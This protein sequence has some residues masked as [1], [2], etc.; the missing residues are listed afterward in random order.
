MDVCEQLPET[1]GRHRVLP[2]LDHLGP[3]IQLL[4]VVVHRHDLEGG[5]HE[6]TRVVAAKPLAQGHAAQVA[7]G[8]VEAAQVSAVQLTGAQ[9]TPD[10]FDAEAFNPRV[11]H[12]GA[13]DGAEQELLGGRISGLR[14][15]R[16]QLGQGI[17]RPELVLGQLDVAPPIEVRRIDE[18][19]VGRQLAARDLGG[20]CRE[21][22]Q[23]DRRAGVK[24]LIGPSGRGRAILEVGGID[25]ETTRKAVDQGIEG[26]AQSLR[27]VGREGLE[28]FDIGEHGGRVPQGA[29]VAAVEGLA[30]GI[31]VLLQGRDR[32]VF[33]LAAGQGRSAQRPE[34]PEEQAAP[35]TVQ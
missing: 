6:A 15:D 9:I 26:R 14:D 27:I 1:T 3:R 24:R 18:L 7:E 25:R 23:P 12:G 28:R 13:P 32:D 4:D 17:R 11:H 29:P 5:R 20:V 16:G 31:P 33:P 21:H 10:P 34:R 8:R 22:E 19:K 35:K 2:G 30:E